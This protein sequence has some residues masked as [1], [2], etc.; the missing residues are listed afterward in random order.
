MATVKRLTEKCRK[1]KKK[2]KAKQLKN[3]VLMNHQTEDERDEVPDAGQRMQSSAVPSDQIERPR[4]SG[5]LNATVCGAAPQSDLVSP[6]MQSPTILD[7]L[8]G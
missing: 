3:R 4:K 7:L 2:Q 5:A 1:R 6:R 8:E